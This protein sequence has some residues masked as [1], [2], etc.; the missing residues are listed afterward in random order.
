[1]LRPTIDSPGDLVFEY[2]GAISEFS[3]IANSYALADYQI[4]R[5]RDI[6][7]THV[8]DGSP[9]IVDLSSLSVGEYK[10]DLLVRD[11]AGYRTDDTINVKIQ[12]TTEPAWNPEPTDKSVE[13]GD[14]LNYDLNATDPSPID[15][16]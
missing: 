12:D 6:I 1:M 8:W 7:A 13:L 14:D 2:Q 5:N 10:Y 3:W 15:T 9:I 16:W 11:Y 4:K